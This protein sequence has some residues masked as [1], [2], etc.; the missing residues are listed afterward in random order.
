MLTNKKELKQRA[1]DAERRA[2][3]HFRKLQKIENILRYAK[4][5][6]EP[7]VHTVKKIEEVI[8]EQYR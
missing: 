8:L 1:E 7:A 5:T 2:L 4:T 3:V 6:K